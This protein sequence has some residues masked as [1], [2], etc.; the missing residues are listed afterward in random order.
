MSLSGK[1]DP[2]MAKRLA[3]QIRTIGKSAK[4]EEDVRL[5]VEAALKH[6]LA[7]LGISTTASYEQPVTLLE[8]SGSADA[9]Y[10]FGIIEYK[11]PGVIGTDAGRKALIE[12]LAGYLVGKARELAPTKPLEP[13]KKMIGIGI[14][15][16]Q[17]MYLRFS[18][19]EN[20]A[21]YFQPVSLETQLDFFR[22]KGFKHGG[23][24][25]VGPM[26]IHEASMDWLLYSL[27]F[28]HRR[29]L[30]PHSLAEVFGPEKEVASATVNALYHKLL[31]STSRR[32]E[33]FFKQWDMIFGVIY[34]QELERGDAAAR[35][36][37]KLY[38]I[39]GK[40]DLK[41]LLFAVHTYYVL[42]M[43]MLAAELISLQEGSW[44]ASFTAEIEAAPEELVKTK[45]E[46]LED[47]GLFK[48]FNIVN[49]LEGDFFRWYLDVWDGSLA[50]NLRHVAMALQQFEPATA[51]IDPDATRDL[52]K[53]LYQ[54][55]LPR[56]V[57][58]D[59]GEYYTPD[60]LAER[61]IRQ[62]GYD[63]NPDKRV[64]DPSCGSGTFLSL[65]IR[66]AFEYADRYLVRPDELIQ[67]LLTNIV[68][69]DLN[70]LAV[71]AARTNFLLSLGTLIRHASRIEIPVYFCDSILTPTEFAHEGQMDFVGS[72]LHDG[73][74]KIQM[75][76]NGRVWHV[77]TSQG[78]FT[79][80]AAVIDREKIETVCALI[81]ESVLLGRTRAQF[82]EKLRAALQHPEATVENLLG[83]V[84]DRVARLNA[85]GKNGIWARFLKNQFAPVFVGRHRFDFV[86]GNP[87][88]VNWQSL[89]DSYRDKTW[90]LWDTYGLFSLS[91]HAARL[92]G[93]KKDLAM[94]F[95]YACLD[96]YVKD[97]G[98]LGFI[99]TQTL[100]KTKGAGDGFR[101]FQLGKK[102]SHF[103]VLQVDDLSDFQPF[104]GATNRTAIVTFQKGKPT[105]YPVPYVY[106][107]KETGQSVG[108]DDDL[109]EVLAKVESKQWRAQPINGED[110]QSPWLTAR[111]KALSALQK[112]VGQSAYRAYAGSCTWANGVY[113]LDVAGK[114]NAGQ[115]LTRNLSDIGKLENI[116]Q[117]EA[118]LEPDLLYPLVRGRD[119]N[120]WQARSS[121]YL[122]NVQDPK[123]RRG[124]DEDW[125]K[126]KH[127]LTYAY[128]LK[129]EEILRQRSGFRKYFCDEDR[130]RC[131]P[132][133]SLYNIG[134]YTLA[135]YKVCW[136]E[137]SN[138]L[139]AGVAEPTKSTKV[140]NSILIPDHTVVF[141]PCKE[142]DEAHYCCALLNSSVGGLIVA[143][144]ITMHPSPHV[145]EHVRLPQFDAQDKQHQRLAE[146]SLQAH[147]LTTQAPDDAAKRL[148]KV[149]AEIDEAAAAA[150]WGISAT[151]LRDIQSSLADL[152]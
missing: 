66:K 29:A 119:V 21:K 92:G 57:R 120:R 152:K 116:P 75:P 3:E 60:W 7:Q 108:L 30:E 98:R 39:A 121:A 52:L 136:P 71:I 141:I 24:Q 37:A 58:H 4:S 56:R 73:E 139:R 144:Y 150:V 8:G 19:S 97:N 83:D 14:D 34:G 147:Q 12:Q 50:Q 143:S 127:P 22:P 148:A 88:W 115:V 138:D 113:W 20:R 41:K 59:L 86:I 109:D 131:A 51:T 33:M 146:L 43:K 42:L 134:D 36:L 87:P 40:P 15:G 31:T 103:Q 112:A 105:K 135:P 85:D 55:L 81:E 28:F 65:C 118:A 111:P 47:G 76:T 123:A 32:V 130:K 128:L 61:L 2:A 145:L 18:S 110:P 91:G 125:L 16:T 45:I 79:F 23:F 140:T 78:R 5:N 27:R 77:D 102:G 62:S 142:R 96:N 54:Y 68:G 1:I 133:Y 122:L 114:N 48:Q 35:E 38:G 117:V 126:T 70:P 10:G 94:L 9:V 63:G 137:L 46:R 17:V 72:A 149:E 124:Y 101:R 99:I 64:L 13:I 151:E 84:F 107:R 132:F 44:F 25:I 74:I 104:E 129:F 53:K 100:F 80:P 90:K 6:H 95:T 69:F 49:F 26:P 82:L 67:K 11:R 106:W 89:S 93:G